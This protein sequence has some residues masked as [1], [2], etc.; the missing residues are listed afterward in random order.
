MDKLIT[1]TTD[2]G[3]QFAS[4]QLHAVLASFGFNGKVVENHSTT[5]FSIIEGSFQI[6][7]LTNFC[8]K[9]SVH[10]G[11]IDPGVGSKRE[12]IVI[13]TNNSYYVGPNNGL[14]YPAAANESI[15]KLWKLDENYF[16]NSVTNTFHG[17]D[18]FIKAAALLAKG[19]KPKSFGCKQISLDKLIKL[20][21]KSGQVLHV[22][23]YG[24][25]KINYNQEN[26]KFN[27][28]KV[29]KK[30]IPF[31]NTFSDSEIGKLIAYIGSSGTLELAVNQGSAN[32]IF[33]LRPGDLIS[34]R[35]EV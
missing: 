5:P 2:F 30:T 6:K 12:G 22:D 28:L 20:E 33:K 26:I 7:T 1:I 13:K 24:N 10:V 16:G 18:V 21:Y 8:P 29:G 31:V 32:K 23:H 25:I 27:K 15:Q 14:F 17:R 9:D 35:N 34:F 3:D 4:S 19:K 11:V